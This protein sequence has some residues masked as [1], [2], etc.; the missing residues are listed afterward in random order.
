MDSKSIALKN[1]DYVLDTIYLEGESFRKVFVA[2]MKKDCNDNYV[3]HFGCGKNHPSYRFF[4]IRPNVH[5][6]FFFYCNF[7]VIFCFFCI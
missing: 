5:F 1:I 2:L 7:I 4:L 3:Q 6:F